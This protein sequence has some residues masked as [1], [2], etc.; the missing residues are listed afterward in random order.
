LYTEVPRR[1]RVLTAEQIHE[2]H[3][4]GGSVILV[5]V[6]KGEALESLRAGSLLLGL[7]ATSG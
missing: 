1:G 3:Y 4:R 5:D 2:Y 7:C 6:S